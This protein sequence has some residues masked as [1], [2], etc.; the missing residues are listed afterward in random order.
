MRP[1]ETI[2]FVRKDD[3][4]QAAVLEEHLI[5]WSGGT[6]WL[7]FASVRPYSRQHDEEAA[8]DV[9]VGAVIAL[10]DGEVRSLVEKFF[11]EKYPSLQV[12]VQARRG[13]VR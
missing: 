2:P 6:G 10:S 13:S 7:M 4:R 9:L 3:Q 8:Y 5:Q 1:A 11:E 12:T